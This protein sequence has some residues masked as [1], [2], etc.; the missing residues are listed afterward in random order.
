MKTRQH[1]LH[2]SI[3]TATT[4][5]ISGIYTGALHGYAIVDPFVMVRNAIFMKATEVALV[6]VNK[7]VVSHD[8]D[9]EMSGL[10]YIHF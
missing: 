9:S 3:Y 4:T 5:K 8:I 1:L 2:H 7:S 10:L 6:L